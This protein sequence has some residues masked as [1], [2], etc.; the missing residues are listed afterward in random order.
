MRDFGGTRGTRWT[1]R[2]GDYGETRGDFGGT[3]GTRWTRRSGDYGEPRGDFGGLGELGGLGG[4]GT[5]FPKF[6]FRSK[7]P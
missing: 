6:I 5:T 7:A 2:S 1:R 4:R 3:R